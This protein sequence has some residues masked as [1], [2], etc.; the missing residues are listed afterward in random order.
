MTVIGETAQ[1]PICSPV[2]KYLGH[3][4]N[5]KTCRKSYKQKKQL[6]LDPSEWR[7]FENTHEA[8]IDRETFGIV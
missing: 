5:F 8:I 7:I 3:T 4:V 2:R 1:F 6:W